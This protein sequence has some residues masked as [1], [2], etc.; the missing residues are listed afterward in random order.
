MI[1]KALP[2]LMVVAVAVLV[3]LLGLSVAAAQQAGI[4][5]SLPAAP[6]SPD[7]EFTVTINDVGLAEGFGEV[8]E[9]LPTGFTYAPDSATSTTAN[10]VAV[11]DV[12]D[13]VVGKV[14]F[15]LVGVDS[16]T[17]DVTVG[18]DVAADVPH[19][20]F[21]VLNKLSGTDTIGGDAEI[22]VV[23]ADTTPPPDMTTPPPDTTTTPPGISRSL[24]AAPVSPDSEFTV[25]IND[26]GLAEGFGEVVETLPTGFTYAPDSATSTTA[27]AV[28]VIDVDDT[29]VGKVTF[30]LV[31]VDSFTYDVTVGSDVAADVPHLFF[32]VLNKLSG[33]DTIGGDASVTVRVDDAP[34]TPPGISRSLPAAPVSPDSEFTVTINDVGLAEGFGEV[35][36]T[37]PT[38]FTYAPDSAT[39]TTANT[40]A[41]IDVDD[42]VPGKV[43]FTLVGVDSFTYD[44]TVGSDVAADVPHLFFG[45][46][47]KLSGTDTIGGDASVTVG[48]PPAPQPTQRPSSNR[49]GVQQPTPVP[50]TP[51]PTPEPTP[52]PTATPAPTPTPEPTPTPTATPAPTPTATPTPTP[53]ATP[54][55]TPTATPAPTPT[56]TPAPTPTATPTPTP[57][58]TRRPTATATAVPPT[59]TATATPEPPTATPQPTPTPTPTATPT[60]PVVTPEEG[61]GFPVWGIVV[62]VIVAVLGLFGG[63]GLFVVLSKDR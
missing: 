3:G 24:P 13:T 50:P 28:A 45:V 14:T 9:T 37:L 54:A 38:G 26:V 52:T 2:V 27:N 62:I 47:N 16:F 5:R 36:E 41:V 58:P 21:G 39:S 43:T 11:I 56:A 4:S 25:T 20:F 7:S 59:P 49:G 34:T 51:T 12:D 63:I 10:T 60:P 1:R 55:P 29:V 57:T 23:E 32:G 40:V 15:T 18:S 44:V 17:Y 31:G 61:G 33:T 8:V 53:T 19:M 48:S 46:L 35:V 30:T 22:T 6:V 42:T